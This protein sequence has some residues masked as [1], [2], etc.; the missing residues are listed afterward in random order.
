TD[1]LIAIYSFWQMSGADLYR[2]HYQIHPIPDLT[3]KPNEI[4][5]YNFVTEALHAEFVVSNIYGDF[6]HLL[7]NLT[8]TGIARMDDPCFIFY[9]TETNQKVSAFAPDLTN[10]QIWQRYR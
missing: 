9:D 7:Y 6:N 2:T 10:E 3:D 4:S 1:Q 5:N 8:S